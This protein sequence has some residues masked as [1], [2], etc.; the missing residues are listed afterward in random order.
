M[1]PVDISSDDSEEEDEEEVGELKQVACKKPAKKSSRASRRRTMGDDED[2]GKQRDSKRRK[3]LGDAPSVPSS[4]YTQTLTQFLSTRSEAQEDWR[5]EDSD[6]ESELALVK[7]TPKANL[8]SR[9]VLGTTS[10]NQ[11]GASSRDAGG[12]PLPEKVTPSN[13]QKRTEIPSSQSPALTPMLLRYS[14]ANEPSPLTARRSSNILA[15]AAAPVSAS[16]GVEKTPRNLIIQDTFST[17][18]SSPTTPT[19]KAKAQAGAANHLRLD[20]PENKENVTPGRTKPKPPKTIFEKV[21]NRRPLC[22]I[23]DSDEEDPDA[24]ESEAETEDGNAEAADKENAALAVG[25]LSGSPLRQHHGERCNTTAPTQIVPNSPRRPSS[26]VQNINETSATIDLALSETTDSEGVDSVEMATSIQASANRFLPSRSQ[27]PSPLKPYVQNRNAVTPTQ[28]SSQ[29][30]TQGVESQ[31]VPLEAIRATGPVSDRSDIII[32][33]YGENVTRM[34]E[35]TKTHE[36]RAWKIPESVHRVWVYVTK[37]ASELRYM[38]LLGPPQTSGQIEG[39]GIGND[40][41]NAGRKKSAAFAYEVLD[42]YE[43]NNPVSLELMKKNG[44]PAA[45][46][47]Y[48]FVPPAIVGQ[49]T[50]NLRCSVLQH[51]EGSDLRSSPVVT[52]SQEL[53]EQIQDDITHSTQLASD[54]TDRISA[55]PTPR[56][57]AAPRSTARAS[58]PGFVKPNLPASRTIPPTQ[59][60]PTQAGGARRRGFV[61]SSQ[62]TTVSQASSSPAP[63]SPSPAKA[64][65]PPPVISLGSSSQPTLP[66]SDNASPSAGR[67]HSSLPSSQFPT[68]SQLL[69]DS[70]INDRLEEPPPLIIWD[71]A[72]ESD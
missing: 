34:I 29:G 64:A 50:S 30:Y 68:K 40:D 31:R 33:I 22:E 9:D 10:N 4:F 42:I 41:F 3:T 2:A 60:L 37:P 53:A 59:E 57:R 8:R 27:S 54:R 69:P 12:V 52:E 19:P 21:S 20:L 46:Q 45:P 48:A 24:T 49:L 28:K 44:W 6:A 72:E 70:L 56:R 38:F 18:H 14:P 32:S 43:L 23:P 16:K 26:G 61:P 51:A 1:E 36:F 5:I 11:A 47:R 13:R 67:H 15:S 35:R 17:T 7:E 66:M 25:D 63:P 58:E 71:S 62:A 55:S 65:A 39:D